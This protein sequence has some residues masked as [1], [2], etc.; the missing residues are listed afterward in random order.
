M[1]NEAS[2][3][4][5]SSRNAKGEMHMLTHPLTAHRAVL[6]TSAGARDM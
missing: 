5:P 1:L 2:V 3:R 6:L 4:T